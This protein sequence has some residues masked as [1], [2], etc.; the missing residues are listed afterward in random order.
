M[1]QRKNPVAAHTWIPPNIGNAYTPLWGVA[2]HFRGFVVERGEVPKQTE[3][4][5]D[6]KGESC[7]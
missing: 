6:A 7:W 3:T 5:R 4:G 1:C 2:G